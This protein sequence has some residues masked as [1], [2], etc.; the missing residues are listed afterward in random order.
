LANSAVVRSNLAQLRQIGV[1]VALDDF[2]TGY[3]S[4]SYLRNYG[5][6]K[7]KIDKSFVQSMVQ[8][9][10]IKSIVEAIVALARAMD[11]SVT[12]EGVESS[13]QWLAATSLDIQEFQGFLIAKPMSEHDIRHLFE[14]KRRNAAG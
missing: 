13:E 11:M 1:R 12:V 14:A 5:I 6:D 9:Q 3:T 7:L 4:I 2:G 8:D 10:S